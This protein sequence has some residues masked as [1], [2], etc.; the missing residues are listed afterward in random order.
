MATAHQEA[1]L[2]QETELQQMMKDKLANLH[3]TQHNKPPTMMETPR[4]I[5]PQDVEYQTLLD[6]AKRLKEKK[7][8]R[9]DRPPYAYQHQQSASLDDSFNPYGHEPNNDMVLTML[10]FL[11]N[12]GIVLKNNSKIETASLSFPDSKG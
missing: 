8:E 4:A 3:A 6:T 12:M 9:A 11:T 2:R 10:T 5:R 7:A 1:L